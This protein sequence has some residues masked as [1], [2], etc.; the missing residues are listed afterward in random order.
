MLSPI[1]S[2]GKRPTCL[3][4]ALSDGHS[5]HQKMKEG[6]SVEFLYYW[7]LQHMAINAINC[8]ITF[9]AAQEALQN[10]GQPIETDWPYNPNQTNISHPPDNIQDIWK[11]KSKWALT[12]DYLVVIDKIRSNKPVVIGINVTN[13]FLQPLAEPYIIPG[14]G[15]GFGKHAVLVVGLGADKNG[16]YYLLIRNSWGTKW[17]NQGYAWIPFTYLDDKF[18]GYMIIV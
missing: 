4:F 7:A 15:I 11:A 14:N 12:S 18:V 13:S 5:F 8:G 17:G 6:L 10:Q 16:N 3:A 1:K 2:Q 9:A